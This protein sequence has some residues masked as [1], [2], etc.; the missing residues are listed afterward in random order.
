MDHDIT[1]PEQVQESSPLEPRRSTR[2]RKQPNF[3]GHESSNVSEIPQSAMETEMISLK[4][5]HVWDLVK[6]PAGKKE[7]LGA[8]G[9]IR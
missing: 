5:N 8:N 4:E 6:L 7:Q 9:Y 3:Y 1:Q 2:T